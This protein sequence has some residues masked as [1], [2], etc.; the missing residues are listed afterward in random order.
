[1]GLLDD[2]TGIGDSPRP[3][4]EHQDAIDNMV[5]GFRSEGNYKALSES[6]ID[7]MN[8]NSEVP[9]LVIYDGES[10]DRYPIVIVEVTTSRQRREIIQ[11][12]RELL[13]K[14]PAVQEAFIF[15]YEKETWARVVRGGKLEE[16]ESYSEA[17]ESDMDDY[18]RW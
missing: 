16:G 6:V 12:V 3:T 4:P 18:Y 7:T 9:D 1:M 11:K 15:D 14:Y 17:L 13:D 2:Y 5:Y 8:L 10:I